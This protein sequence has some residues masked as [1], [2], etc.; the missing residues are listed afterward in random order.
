MDR[1]YNYR[2]RGYCYRDRGYFIIGTGY[3]VIMGGVG[4]GKS[5]VNVW[6]VAREMDIRSNVNDGNILLRY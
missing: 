1:G 2:D 5:K 3:I 6:T 4:I